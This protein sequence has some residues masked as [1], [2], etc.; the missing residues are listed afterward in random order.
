MIYISAISNA[1]NESKDPCTF[2]IFVVS[3]TFLI[4]LDLVL[5]HL[6]LDRSS[7]LTTTLEQ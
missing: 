2:S 4:N 1:P 7:E 5:Y 6:T 3:L